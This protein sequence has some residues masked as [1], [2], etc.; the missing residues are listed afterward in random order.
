MLSEEIL[1]KEN[2]DSEKCCLRGQ[3]CSCT[4]SP[5]CINDK[6]YDLLK[7]EKVI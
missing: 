3:V 2:K 6:N 7:R 5:E 4:Q 1:E